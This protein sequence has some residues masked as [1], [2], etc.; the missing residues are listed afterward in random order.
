MLFPAADAKL[1]AHHN[2]VA[3][4]R[5]GDVSRREHPYIL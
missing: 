3:L 2:R 5:H 4:F 1:I